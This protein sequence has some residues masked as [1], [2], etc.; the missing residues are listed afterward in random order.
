MFP[1]TAEEAKMHMH[2]MEIAGFP[3]CVSSTDAAHITM[4]RYP[5]KY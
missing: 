1:T 2:E 4:D 5:N 3:G